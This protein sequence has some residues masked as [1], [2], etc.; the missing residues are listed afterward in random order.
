MHSGSSAS[1]AK[2]PSYLAAARFGP[3]GAD[4]LLD[5]CLEHLRFDLVIVLRIVIECYGFLGDYTTDVL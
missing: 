4:G 3:D 5:F 2:C 1:R